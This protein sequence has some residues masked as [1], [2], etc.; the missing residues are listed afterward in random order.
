MNRY[1]KLTAIL[2]LFFLSAGLIIAHN[3]P[4]TGYEP[5]IYASTPVLTWLFIALAMLGGA[6]IIIQQ[7]ISRGYKTS[8]MWFSGLMLL[9]VSKLSFLYV[10][11]IR[12]YISWHGDNI[13]H[14]GFVKDILQGGD[15]ST[16]NFYPITHVLN[17]QNILITDVA[18]HF[19][20]NLSTSI[21]SILFIIFTYL[22]ATAIL[23]KRGQQVMATL[24][25]AAVMIGG[26][27][28]F[29][30][31]PNGWSVFLLPLLFFL[32][33]KQQDNKI[34]TIPF[35]IVLVMYPFFHVL[36]GLMI[37]VV[38]LLFAIMGR[39][40]LFFEKR[41]NRPLPLK[42]PPPIIFPFMI[43]L[44]ILIPWTL[45]F[46]T[47]HLNLR[48]I[49]EQITSGAPGAIGETEGIL[50]KL[51]LQSFDIVILYL[52]LYG[53]LTILIILTVVGLILIWRR[54]RKNST[55]Y[56][57]APLLYMGVISL[58]FGFLYFLYFVG[59]PGL[60]AIDAERMLA[61]C[62]L[63]TP[64]LA[65]VCLYRLAYLIKLRYL[66]F[67]FIFIIL[68]VTAGMSIRDVYYSPY[69]IKPNLQISA[70]TMQ[71]AEWFV[72]SKEQDSM[73]DT[74]ETKT[75][76]R[77]LADA[78]LGYDKARERSDFRGPTVPD[79]FGYDVNS[80]FGQGISKNA[81]LVLSD[82]D[83]ITYTSI[84]EAVGRFKEEDFEQLEKD[85]T[86]DKLYS[87]GECKI[88]LISAKLY[89]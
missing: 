48:V 78:I 76:P 46:N 36:T 71:G 85:P 28:N 30:L 52:K 83:Q 64:L 37:A 47:F 15:Y 42:K 61:Y 58:F 23:P 66:S 13:T 73:V 51:G 63:F 67:V 2:S 56:S 26:I 18:D 20:L 7:I 43:V 38:F 35:L 44:A 79:H 5:D 9:M 74:L 49:W 41:S 53:A 31:M 24:I 72:E 3:S 69:N 81:F 54:M 12:G 59:A 1:F 25:A 29:L 27:Y 57:L 8:N 55:N 34:Y 33:F 82:I 89:R 50:S 16:S 80:V 62:M 4:A 40:L 22:L 60:S 11:Y 75:N 21:I 32:Y 39:V 6:V 84:W 17:A 14:W 70:S 77:R 88:Y 87:N 65:A 45:A 86:V 10:P 68:I 19:I